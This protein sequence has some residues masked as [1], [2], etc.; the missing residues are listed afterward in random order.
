M[1]LIHHFQMQSI[2]LQI[3]GVPKLIMQ[4]SAVITSEIEIPIW[5]VMFQKLRLVLKFSF[6]PPDGIPLMQSCTETLPIN[7]KSYKG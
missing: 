7:L 4:K 3:Q 6:R 2:L 1:E 5:S